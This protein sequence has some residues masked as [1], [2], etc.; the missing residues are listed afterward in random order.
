MQ[1]LQYKCPHIAT[2]Q[3]TTISRQMGQQASLK[4]LESSGRGRTS[5]LKPKRLDSH[6]PLLSKSSTTRF[7]D[8]S[9]SLLSRS[10]SRWSTFKVL[11]LGW[12]KNQL[13]SGLKKVIYRII[14]S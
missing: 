1:A 6:G 8:V 11:F 4:S 3:P 5:A 9:S 7:S 10:A 2:R 14:S 12:P 13:E